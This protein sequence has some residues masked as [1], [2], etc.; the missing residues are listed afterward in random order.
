MLEPRKATG[1]RIDGSTDPLWW[2]VAAL[3]SLGSLWLPKFLS[4][5]SDQTTRL[6]VVESA[7]FFTGALIGCFRPRRVWRWGAASL[8]T[9]A[10]RDLVW[11]FNDPNLSQMTGLQ[12]ASYLMSHGDIYFVQAVPVLVGAVLGSCTMKAGLE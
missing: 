5:Q 7:L 3:L 11:A 10:I 12:T 4:M 8:I 1:T 9:F 2:G 6:I